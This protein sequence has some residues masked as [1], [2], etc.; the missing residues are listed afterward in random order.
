MIRE[1]SREEAQVLS[2]RDDLLTWNG[3]GGKGLSSSSGGVR[4]TKSWK[5]ITVCS[6]PLRDELDVSA[7]FKAVASEELE[8]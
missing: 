8:G 1:A 5:G 6:K 3:V 2:P 7:L 4:L